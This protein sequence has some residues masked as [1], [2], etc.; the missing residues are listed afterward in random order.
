MAGSYCLDSLDLLMQK[1]FG[2]FLLGS[3]E[4][5]CLD[6]VGASMKPTIVIVPVKLNTI[7]AVFRLAK[8][9]LVHSNDN[10][11]IGWNLRSGQLT[12][13]GSLNYF[14]K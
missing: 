6:E 14:E 3:M 8:M 4:V 2:D 5:N 9:K 12:D 11:V 13:R 7:L 10:W 1:Q